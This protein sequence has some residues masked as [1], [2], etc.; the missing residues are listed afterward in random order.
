MQGQLRF[1]ESPTNDPFRN[2]EHLGGLG[3]GEV[4]VP[5]QVENLPRLV[6]KC[7]DLLVELG[8]VRQAAWFI[9]LGR[10]ALQR[11]ARGV[12]RPDSPAGVVG[13]DPLGAVIVPRQVDQLAAN[14]D[15]GQIE[16]ARGDSGVMSFKAAT[17]PQGGV[18]QD[19]V[20]L[21]PAGDAGIGPE[22][23]PRE[24]D[25]PV[26]G[27]AQE[28]TPGRFVP[29]P[30]PVEAELDLGVWSVASAMASP[31]RSRA[32]SPRR[33]RSFDACATILPC[34]QGGQ[35][36]FREKIRSS[37][38]RGDPTSAHQGG[39][40]TG[41]LDQHGSDP[42]RSPP[43]TFNEEK[44][45]VMR[46]VLMSLAISCTL[47][48]GLIGPAT[49]AQAAPAERM[50][51]SGVGQTF[52][53]WYRFPG[54]RWTGVFGLSFYDACTAR[55]DHPSRR[56]ILRRSRRTRPL[57]EAEGQSVPSGVEEGAGIGRS[58]VSRGPAPGHA[59]LPLAGR[60]VDL[61]V[62]PG[63]ARRFAGP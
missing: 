35:K 46:R 6:R 21:F 49:T 16:E 13:A 7:L 36:P 41:R 9:R 19:V 23:L 4:L 12:L 14:L 62:T 29:G 45:S 2:A 31:P 22:H 44:E 15:R 10:R 52:T 3:L 8:P 26:A 57:S 61:V 11:S 63:R 59:A 50:T 18:L 1:P 5:D 60:L 42:S 33:Q 28:L 37:M 32:G 54:Q 48:S 40:R 53:V 47:A 17:E 34:R 24:P 51:E 25:E 58:V 55:P 30:Q 56:A 20:G 38:L 43:S 27:E 39:E